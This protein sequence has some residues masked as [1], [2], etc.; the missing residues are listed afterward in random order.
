MFTPD[1]K[2]CLL[3]SPESIGALQFLADCQY[4]YRVFPSPE[5]AQDLGGGG[6]MFRNGLQAMFIQ[7][8][9]ACQ[10]FRDAT[11]ADGRKID[12]DVAEVPV[13]RKKATVLFANC[14]V[15]RRDG[16]NEAEA[17][18]LMQ[19]LTGVEGQKHQAATGRDM[20]SFVQVAK[21][22]IFLDP[23]YPP[24]HDEIFLKAAQTARPLEID[25]TTDAWTEIVNAEISNIFIAHKDVKK[26]MRDATPRVNAILNGASR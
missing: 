25:P 7:G 24:Q 17:W 4:K 14:Y 8:R 26:A 6:E 5:Q 16:P 10:S 13:H 2:R 3:D 23:N 19:W 12:W 21:S 11:Y 1:M 15:L 18:K 9:W 22:P 20:P